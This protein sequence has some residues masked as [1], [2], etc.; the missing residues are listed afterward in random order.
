[1]GSKHFIVGL[2]GIIFW[3]SWSVSLWSLSKDQIVSFS[4]RRRSAVLVWKFWRTFPRYVIMPKSIVVPVGWLVGWLIG[5][6]VGSGTSVI[7]FIFLAFGAIPL[8]DIV[9]LRNLNW[10]WMN[11]HLVWFSF[12]PDY[13]IACRTSIVLFFKQF[14]CICPDDD[15]IL[16]TPYCQCESHMECVE[17]W[18]SHREIRKWEVW[19]FLHSP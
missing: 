7:A 15:V 16:D 10:R 2:W 8:L 9:C 6:L 18:N 12:I 17:I 4:R 11:W 1:M 5:W 14:R 13:L 19:S 3:R